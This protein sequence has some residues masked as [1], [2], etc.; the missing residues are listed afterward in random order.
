MEQHMKVCPHCGG[1]Y[2]V[3]EG[4]CPMDGTRLRTQGVG[5]PPQ[6]IDAWADAL[7][8][9]VLD[10]RYRLDSVIGEGGMGLVFKATHVLIG[11]PLAVKLLRREHID[12][13]D[14]ARRFLLE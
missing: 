6:P 1:A 5:A 2:P 3:V 14:V 7:L 11:K 9:T 12:A 8:G 4:F 13:P 10:R